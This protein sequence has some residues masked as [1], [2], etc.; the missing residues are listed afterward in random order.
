MDPEL[1]RRYRRLFHFY[2]VQARGY[3]SLESS[4]RQAAESIA[5]RWLG[6]STHFPDLLGLLIATYKHENKRRDL[7]NRGIVNE[8]HFVQ[9][10]AEVIEAFAKYPEKSKKFIAR[11]AG[12]FFDCLD[13]NSDGVLELDDIEAYAKAYGKPTGGVKANLARMLKA[14][15]LPPDQLPREIFL[16]LVTQYWFDPSPSVP[17]RWLFDF[18]DGPIDTNCLIHPPTTEQ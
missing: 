6:S 5:A 12:G 18:A 13:L 2:D 14:F 9:S 8:A 15:D 10:H 1:Q 3:L 11:A 17:G 7:D 4:F 16:T